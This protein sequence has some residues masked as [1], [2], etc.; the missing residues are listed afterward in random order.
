MKNVPPAQAVNATPSSSEFLTPAE[1]SPASSND[2]KT[3]EKSGQSS[4]RPNHSLAV[5]PESPKASSR[6]KKFIDPN[7]ADRLQLDPHVLA[8]IDKIISGGGGKKVSGVSF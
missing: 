3:R 7:L 4:S 6:P 5:P 8:K 2:E 1:P